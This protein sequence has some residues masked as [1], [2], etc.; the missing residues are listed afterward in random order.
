MNLPSTEDCILTCEATLAMYM[1]S[2]PIWVCGVS[3]FSTFLQWFANRGAGIFFS[4]EETG[5]WVRY[6]ER[7]MD[8]FFTWWAGHMTDW[9][10]FFLEKHMTDWRVVSTRPHLSCHLGWA[11]PT[12][13]RIW[14]FLLH[15]LLAH[16]SWFH[17]LKKK[18]RSWFQVFFM[19]W[20]TS[21][22]SSSIEK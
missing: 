6:S 2:H 22:Y 20:S 9:F 18:K 13:I 14:S 21:T 4:V 3:P 12:W 5:I 10:F 16:I 11:G 7:I 17:F 8:R 19:M 15:I 1:K